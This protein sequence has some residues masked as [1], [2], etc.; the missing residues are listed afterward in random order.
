[1]LDVCRWA[2]QGDRAVMSSSPRPIFFVHL[3]KTAGTSL[4]FRLRNQFPRDAIYPQK[5]DEGSV[6]AVLT[7]DHL[8]RAWHAHRDEIRIVT[9][10]FP[11]CTTQLLGGE[12]TTF[13]VLREPVERTL[14]YLRHHRKLTPED[15]DR[16]LEEIYD[17]PF[18]FHGLI[19]NHM[20]KMLS[21]T[22]TEM[23]DGMLTRVEFTPDRLE[24]AKENLS[25]VD[26]VGVHSHFDEFCD[27]LA[28]HFGWDLG[29]PQHANR[30]DSVDVPTSFRDRIAED[31]AMD[32][33]LYELAC[34]LDEQRRAANQGGSRPASE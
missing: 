31:N 17:D 3:Q 4:N 18:R 34:R 32:R 33:E 14:S 16:S 24:R 1:M 30:T 12:F 10:H 9:G 8:L 28:R 15:A 2:T 27:D 19:H 7:V 22:T 6:A 29:A 5:V 11:L 21:L 20:V 25:G 13:T 23:N 26:F